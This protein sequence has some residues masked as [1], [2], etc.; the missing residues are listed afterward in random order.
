[1]EVAVCA[2]TRRW[3]KSTTLG[4]GRAV[5]CLVSVKLFGLGFMMKKTGFIVAALL[6]ALG[7]AAAAQAADKSHST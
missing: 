1:M 5:V 3:A 6:A 2:D 7:F 4:C